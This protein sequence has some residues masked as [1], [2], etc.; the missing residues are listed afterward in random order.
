MG[1]DFDP[2]VLEY[3]KGQNMPVIYGDAEDPELM[4]HLPV[5]HAAW[6]LCVLPDRNANLALFRM[7][8]NSS[9]EGRIVAA[10]RHQADADLYESAGADLVL[11]PFVDA[12]EA[13]VDSLTAAMHALP[14]KLAWPASLSEVRLKSG[15]MFTGKSIGQ[16]PLRAETGVSILAVTR[17][18]KSIFNPGPE[19]QLYPGDHLVLLGDEE[20]LK[21]AAE[22]LEQRD[23]A[24]G[25]EKM[26][27]SFSIG[28]VTIRPDSPWVG[29]TLMN[30]NLRRDHGLTVIGIERD[31]RQMNAPSAQE[32]LRGNDRL[33]LAGSRAAL[34]RLLVVS[35]ETLDAESG[36]AR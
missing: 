5:R 11:R 21:K 26:T 6:A 34:D 9:F 28:Q 36:T 16:I 33:I 30:L 13:A 7:L 23:M 2:A 10:A 27:Q 12:A 19:F 15:S 24:I 8:R 17:A 29:Q 14:Q 31:G 4:D 35:A 32:T 25:E 3:W 1:V 20:N 18:G 22:Y